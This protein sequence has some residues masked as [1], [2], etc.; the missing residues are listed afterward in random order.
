MNFEFR[1][2]EA[3]EIEEALIILREAAKSLQSKKINQWAFWLTPSE[4]KINWIK[5]GF[6]N[7]EFYFIIHNNEILGMFRL[8]DKDE[9]YW[10]KEVETA[11]Y[12]HSFVIREK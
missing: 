5:E 3:S 2:A 9:L 11:K 4:G 8:L 6:L 10:G 12:I 1:Q 7:K